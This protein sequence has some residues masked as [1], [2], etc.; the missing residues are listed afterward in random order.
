MCKVRPKKSNT[1]RN[2]ITI[3]GNRICYPEDVGTKTPTLEIVKMMINSV[4]SCRGA[5]FCHSET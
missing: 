2:C 1:N 5:K 4:L 3:G